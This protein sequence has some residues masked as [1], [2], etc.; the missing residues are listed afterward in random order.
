M[1]DEIDSPPASFSWFSTVLGMT[2]GTVLGILS[3]A[4]LRPPWGMP[5]ACLGF[6]VPT[7]LGLAFGLWQKTLTAKNR[8][9]GDLIRRSRSDHR[10]SI[11]GDRVR[12]RVRRGRGRAPDAPEHAAQHAAVRALRARFGA[13]L[14]EGELVLDWDRLPSERTLIEHHL[15]EAEACARWLA[16]FADPAIA[17]HTA[18]LLTAPRDVDTVIEHV[19]AVADADAAL[20][21]RLARRFADRGP[22]VQLR[23]AI[24]LG[25]AERIDAWLDH[26]ARF[27]APLVAQA[28]RALWSLDGTPDRAERW[29]AHRRTPVRRAACTL[30]GATLSE[31]RLLTLLDDTSDDVAC[32]AAAALFEREPGEAQVQAARMVLRRAPDDRAAW[33]AADRAP[34]MVAAMRVIGRLGAATDRAGVG[35]WQR[36]GPFVEAAAEALAGL[37][38]RHARPEAGAVS[39]GASPRL[40]GAVSVAEAARAAERRRQGESTRE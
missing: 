5:L 36:V 35:P 30:A 22:G 4:S 25:D 16:R 27:G 40:E 10:L 33:M 11:E 39:L 8:V 24:A 38:A 34:T 2:I 7:A 15:G 19:T 37:D 1:I 31:A 17:W 12:L 18:L 9:R 26:E 21:T 20:R 23:V 28:T 13:R 29:A 3:L 32:A 14:V 6:V